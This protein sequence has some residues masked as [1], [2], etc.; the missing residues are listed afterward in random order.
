MRYGRVGTPVVICRLNGAA[1]YCNHQLTAE[2]ERREQ[3]R[4]VK[5]GG[6]ERRGVKKRRE[7]KRGGERRGGEV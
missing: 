7:E 4:E 5:R 3:E 1:C 6:K 2:E